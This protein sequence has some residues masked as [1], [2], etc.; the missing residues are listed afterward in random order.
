M[1]FDCWTGLL[2]EGKPYT[3]VEKIR[4]REKA[5]DVRW[6]EY[7][8]ITGTEE[9]GWWLSVMD[10]GLP[11]TL[12][13]TVSQVTA[14]KQYQLRDQGKELVIGIWGVSDASVGDEASYREYESEDGK[15][16]FFL[17]N[18]AE[19][20]IGASGWHVDPAQIHLDPTETA[21][22]RAKSLKWK[23]WKRFLFN[24][25]WACVAL[26]FYIF[27]LL[28]LFE[29]SADSFRWHDVRRFLH[30]PYRMEERLSDAPYYTPLKDANTQGGHL[31]ESTL[32]PGAS[33]M[34]IIEGIDGWTQEVRQ[35]LAAAD[36]AIVIKTKDEACLV[37]TTTDGNTLIWVGSIGA[38]PIT[39]DAITEDAAWLH[40]DE[41]LD[42]YARLIRLA[43]TEGRLTVIQDQNRR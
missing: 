10:G 31:Y 40:Q 14:P 29:D 13:R 24:R 15:Y 23:V 8:L 32:D 11:C 18:W 30:V 41:T 35:D 7:G 5:S 39:E 4:Y 26:L 21:A 33:A 20:R 1:D 36:Q 9:K 6:T 28:W 12:S 34:D 27:F 3:I 25:C 16:T 2:I 43:S 22:V 37:S 19:K 38:L 42:R 17:E